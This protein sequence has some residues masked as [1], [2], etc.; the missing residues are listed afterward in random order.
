VTSADKMIARGW[1]EF[2][3]IFILVLLP[4]IAAVTFAIAAA[5]HYGAAAMRDAPDLPNLPMAMIGGAVAGAL[6]CALAIGAVALFAV[7]KNCLPV[8]VTIAGLAGEYLAGR[9][10]DV[11]SALLRGMLCGA[12]FFPA[13]AGFMAALLAQVS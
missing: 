7:N 10:D 3:P 9:V 12:I 5:L 6:A 4:F 11:R 8:G 1:A 2:M 13:G